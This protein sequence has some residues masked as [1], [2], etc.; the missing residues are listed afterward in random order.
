MKA[1]AIKNQML[2]LS[3]DELKNILNEA[4]KA[5]SNTL[6]EEIDKMKQE[7][8]QLKESNIE[9]VKML[10][11]HPCYPK[12]DQSRT[13]ATYHDLNELFTSVNTIADKVPQK[14]METHRISAE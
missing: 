13:D 5:N 3:M 14:K 8:R 9:M 7:I 12:F 11:N 6:L 4:L 10:A 1:E 2:T